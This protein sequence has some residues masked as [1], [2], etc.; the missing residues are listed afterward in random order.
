[1]QGSLLN[2]ENNAD[3]SNAG[4]DLR[5]RLSGLFMLMG[6][7]LIRGI[8]H[9]LWWHPLLYFHKLRIAILSCISHDSYKSRAAIYCYFTSSRLQ[10]TPFYDPSMHLV[11]FTHLTSS[12]SVEL[13]EL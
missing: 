10:A 7:S 3:R 5:K 2:I 4:D 12:P 1:M 9:I 11:R 8:H 6:L 13:V